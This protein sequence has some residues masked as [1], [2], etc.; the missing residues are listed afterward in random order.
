MQQV[1]RVFVQEI[2]KIRAE[3]AVIMGEVTILEFLAHL[4]AMCNE[5]D[6]E[7]LRDW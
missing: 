6:L 3:M 1:G 4:R 5:S 7:R 2:E